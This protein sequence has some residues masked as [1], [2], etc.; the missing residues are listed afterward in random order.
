MFYWIVFD[1][2][3]FVLFLTNSTAMMVTDDFVTCHHSLMLFLK[4]YFIGL[5]LTHLCLFLTDSTTM[6]T[7][8]DFLP[9]LIFLIIKSE[10]P[11]W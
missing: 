8:D 4:F 11:N 5:F 9:I 10:I 6:M 7:T 1:T 2:F 3:V